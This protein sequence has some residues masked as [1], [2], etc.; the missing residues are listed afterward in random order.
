MKKLF[1]VAILSF[2][3]PASAAYA[4][5]YGIES[6]SNMSQQE[7]NTYIPGLS[8]TGNEI[9]LSRRGSGT[10]SGTRS[11]KGGSGGRR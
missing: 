7:H 6:N 8:E 9:E 11:G 10:R 3:L 1:T 5:D 2:A 4:S